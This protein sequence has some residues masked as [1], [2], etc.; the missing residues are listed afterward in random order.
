VPCLS[1]GFHRGTQ[2]TVR[3]TVTSLRIF[4]AEC[5]HG[6]REDG[7]AKFCCFVTMRHLP[8]ENNTKISIQ[9]IYRLTTSTIFARLDPSEYDLLNKMKEPLYWR[10]FRTS[11]E[12]ERGV[13]DS[14]HSVPKHWFAA[15]IRKLPERWQRCIDVG[16]D[17]V[18]IRA[19]WFVTSRRR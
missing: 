8:A 1:S 4:R 10:K 18:E 5:N 9:G 14:V 16:G 6:V 3:C 12:Q 15:A 11:D 7:L 2:W 17:Y 19:V 13:R